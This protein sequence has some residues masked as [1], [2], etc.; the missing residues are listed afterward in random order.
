M[1]SISQTSKPNYTARVNH[2]NKCCSDLL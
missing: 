1:Y 2:C